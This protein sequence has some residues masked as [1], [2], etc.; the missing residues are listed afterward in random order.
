MEHSLRVLVRVDTAK[1]SAA[2]E[3]RGCLTPETYPSLVN[4]LR[5][6]A[7]LG[8]VMAVN[9][10][11]ARHIDGEALRALLDL[12]ASRIAGGAPF[13]GPA[14]IPASVEVPDALPVCAP[15][16]LLERGGPA[17]AVVP[18]PAPDPATAAGTAAAPA[19]P[20]R[21]PLSNEEAF[22]RAFL[23]H[24]SSVLRTPQERPQSGP[25]PVSGFG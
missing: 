13:G 2:I 21:R 16:G 17:S 24:D 12:T 22:A 6:T 7:T 3:V 1:A 11:R 19:T 8:A 23:L 10:L 9:L 4:I 14:G 18:G 15:R 25:R 20:E 5:H